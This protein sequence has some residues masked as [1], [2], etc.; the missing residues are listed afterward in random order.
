MGAVGEGG[1]WAPRGASA[2]AATADVGDEPQ[3]VLPPGGVSAPQGGG[4]Q[5]GRAD[6]RGV[7]PQRRGVRVQEVP[8]LRPRARR[9]AEHVRQGQLLRQRHH[10]KPLRQPQ[11]TPRQAR[12]GA[13]GQGRRDDRRGR[14]VLQRG[15]HTAQARRALARGVPPGVREK[16]GK[17]PEIGHRYITYYQSVRYMKTDRC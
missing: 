6:S 11:G 5:G 12:Q 9:G 7:L 4:P 3:H 10:R 2:G 17:R 8:A 13:G 15:A 14:E 1:E 16:A